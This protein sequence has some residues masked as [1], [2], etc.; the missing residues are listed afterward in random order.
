MQN[1]QDLKKE[2]TCC[3]RVTLDFN[4]SKHNSNS[5]CWKALTKHQRQE[6]KLATQ[7]PH[8]TSW[9]HRSWYCFKGL[10]PIFYHNQFSNTDALEQLS[11]AIEWPSAKMVTFDA[12]LFFFF[13]NLRPG[14]SG[15]ITSRWRFWRWEKGVGSDYAFLFGKMAATIFC[16]MVFQNTTSYIPPKGCMKSY[17]EMSY[18][19]LHDSWFTRLSVA[20][21]ELGSLGDA[22]QAQRETHG[23]GGNLT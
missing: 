20:S 14:F 17:Y 12:I 9:K 22:K 11:L 13:R 10:T 2:V 23:P 15:N 7:K 5:T 3:A 19:M 21:A 18:F 8:E 16:E 4:W 6:S 1:V